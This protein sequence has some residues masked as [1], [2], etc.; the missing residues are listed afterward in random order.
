MVQKIE[1]QQHQIS[2]GNHIFPTIAKD[3]LAS[4]VQRASRG[5]HV[6]TLS[7]IPRVKVSD[8]QTASIGTLPGDECGS[9]DM[10]YIRHEKRLPCS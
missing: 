7:V 6:D 2:K 5:Q 9:L 10:T 3:L 8:A 1:F 4:S